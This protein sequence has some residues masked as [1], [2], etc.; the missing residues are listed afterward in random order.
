MVLVS[1]NSQTCRT[2]TQKTNTNQIKQYHQSTNH[3]SI[4]IQ[5]LNPSQNTNINTPTRIQTQVQ[6]IE[7]I[8]ELLVT[9]SEMQQNSGR[10]DRNTQEDNNSQ[11]I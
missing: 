7:L 2:Y 4:K 3:R 5:P 9:G 1:H 10:K 11:H 6:C 8:H